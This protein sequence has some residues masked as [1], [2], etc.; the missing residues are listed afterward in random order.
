MTYRV[1]PNG[2]YLVRATI[3]HTKQ[4][5]SKTQYS[6]NRKPVHSSQLYQQFKR[7]WNKDAIDVVSKEV[8]V[9]EVEVETNGKHILKQHIRLFMSQ[10]DILHKERGQIL[11]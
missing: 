5:S 1:I 8:E 7:E 4:P 2:I 10:N 3:I 6:H 9:E 11:K